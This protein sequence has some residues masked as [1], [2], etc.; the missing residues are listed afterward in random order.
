M[1][2]S[3]PTKPRRLRTLGGT[4][5]GLDM[6]S[7]R[8]PPKMAEGFY[9]SVEWTKLRALLIRQRGHRCEACWATHD[10]LGRPVRLIADHMTERRDGGADLDP[11]NIRLMCMKCHN[12]K[13]AREAARR[14]A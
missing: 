10:G 4:V 5:A 8:P 13:T 11:C 12:K 1:H 2:K 14:I 9:Q 7:T 3:D 6:R